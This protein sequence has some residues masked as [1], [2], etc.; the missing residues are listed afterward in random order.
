MID[1]LTP[2]IAGPTPNPYETRLEDGRTSEYYPNAIMSTPP[3]FTPAYPNQSCVSPVHHAY[4]GGA[5][6]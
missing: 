2:T 6:G 4:M 5:G 3:Q 1:Y